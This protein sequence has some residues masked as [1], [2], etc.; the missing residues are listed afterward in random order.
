ML[1]GIDHLVIAVH[2]PDAAA[3]ALEREVGLAFTGGGRHE[4]AGTFNRLAFLGDSYVELIGVFD[5]ALVLS[6]AAFAVGRASLTY[7]EECGEGLATWAVATDNIAADAARLQT[8]GS[9]IAAPAA[10]SRTRPDGEVVRWHTAFPPLGP[11]MPPFLIEHEFTGA[12]W[13]DEARAARAAFRHP[14]GGAVRLVSLSIPGADPATWAQ[15]L[16]LAFTPQG[17][18]EI[19]V[20][21]VSIM[22][23]GVVPEVRLSAEADTAPPLDLTRFGIR[24][25]RQ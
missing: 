6:N 1:I 9:P 15:T 17:L 24:W 19:G 4:H 25:R 11:A 12:E 7:L 14:V 2:D 20:Q 8:G 5:R 18:C 21:S 23:A 13:G 22:G 10:G 3:E 16:G